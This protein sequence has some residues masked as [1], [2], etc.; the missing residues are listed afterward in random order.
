M[1]FGTQCIIRSLIIRQEGNSLV[2]VKMQLSN[3]T[4]YLLIFYSII[5][6]VCLPEVL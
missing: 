1:F 4:D 5:C 3:I 6:V 2:A